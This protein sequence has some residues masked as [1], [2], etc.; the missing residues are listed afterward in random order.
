MK[1]KYIGDVKNISC[2]SFL[3]I[4]T[5]L[6]STIPNYLMLIVRPI[7]VDAEVT[8]SYEGDFWK[9]ENTKTVKRFIKG[10]TSEETEFNI[11][12]IGLCHL[13]IM[14]ICNRPT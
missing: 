9:C 6:P 2:R 13:M 11:R 14:L 3:N 1:T 12:D 4:E 5:L 10:W 8:C 7:S